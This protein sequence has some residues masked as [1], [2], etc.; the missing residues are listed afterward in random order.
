MWKP[1]AMVSSKGSYSSRLHDDDSAPTLYLRSENRSARTSGHIPD[2]EGGSQNA[3]HAETL[4]ASQTASANVQRNTSVRS[5]MTLPAYSP[6]A[7]E[8]ERILGREGER[9]GIDVV[10]EAPETVDE[11]EERRDEE[12][13]SLYQIRLQR[14]LEVSDREERR[15]RRRD[16]RERGDSNTLQ[17][18]RHE[19]HLRRAQREASGAAV[20]IAEHQSRSR[21]RRVSSVSYAELGVAR[22]DGTRIRAGSAGSDRQP[23]LDSAASI[24]GNSTR[25]WLT[26]DSLSAHTRD[27][28]AS[29]AMSVSDFSDS[30]LE[31]PPLGRSG[32]DFEVVTLGHG[33]SR[34]ASRSATP[35]GPRSR[36]SSNLAVTRLSAD[37]A[38]LGERRVIPSEPPAYDGSGFEEAPPYEPPVRQR[39]P[40]LPTEER[41]RQ[42][43][44]QP[45][46]QP[47]GNSQPEPRRQPQ[48]QSQS[49]AAEHHRSVSSTGAPLLPEISR[50]PSIRIAEATPIEAERSPEFPTPANERS[51][52]R[53]H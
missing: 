39:A 20:M 9:G 48:Q 15:Q 38:D 46:P 14:R 16:A 52:G 24:S 33:R 47:Q 3:M 36:A 19:S 6:A 50:L 10:V 23:L 40:Q 21:E 49:R 17:A 7:R 35:S 30:E 1:R 45:Q 2:L 29:S 11:E 34:N 51:R 8:N 27:W 32:S 5:V 31:M 42:S 28:S 22:H 25:P 4:E 44:Q 37:N 26:S 43:Q 12:M 41:E 18:L 13:E 53:A